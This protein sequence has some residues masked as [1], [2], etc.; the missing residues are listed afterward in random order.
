LAFNPNP[1]I[2]ED[3]S[4]VMNV[5]Y[6]PYSSTDSNDGVIEC[7]GAWLHR[8]TR[9][10]VTVLAIGGQ[11]DACN[12]DQIREHA[13]RYISGSAALVVDMT[14][15]EFFAV[16]GLRNLMALGER[17]R[18]VGLEWVLVGSPSVHRLL[19]VADVDRALPI[20]HS[21]E[22]ALQRFAGRSTECL[23]TA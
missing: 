5:A 15:V 4:V 1:E 6:Y 11:I 7:R 10:G 22:A 14:H 21:T 2:L 17:C 19:R 8:Y 23:E 12:A 18:K 20:E 13:H 16:Q 3:G 9:G